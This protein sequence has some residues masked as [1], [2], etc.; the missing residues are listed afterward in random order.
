MSLSAT[1]TEEWVDHFVTTPRHR[2]HYV[3]AGSGH[4]VLLLHGG[5]PGASGTSN[6]EPNIAPLAEHFRVVVPDMPGWGESDTS[7]GG[8]RDHPEILV[9]LLDA[10]DIE[11]AAVVGNSV[12]GMTVVTT[13]ITHPERV[14][15]LI[16]MG[17]PAPARLLL[18]AGDGPTEGMRALTAAY[19][20]PTRETVK[21]FVDVMCFDPAFATD[22]LITSRLDAALAHPEH[23]DAWNAARAG[24]GAV[25]PYFGLGDQLAGISAP[26]MVMQ[27]RND[28]TVH[29]ENALILAARISD[30]RLVMLNRC[31]HWAQLEHAAEF[32]RLVTSFLGAV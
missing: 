21:A 6:F 24:A 25:S 19:R 28:R 15:H 14:S 1:S 12:G 3:E 5:G 17:A 16:T 27:G 18:A 9:E 23:L 26:T 10:L 31:G 11:R 2:I 4:P 7:T 22:D 30:S 32:N 13:A 8:G 20:N 29:F